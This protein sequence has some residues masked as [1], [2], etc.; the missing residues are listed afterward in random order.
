METKER[1]SLLLIIAALAIEAKMDL[2][3]QYAAETNGVIASRLSEFGAELS[4]S[5]IADKLKQAQKIKET[6]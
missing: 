3:H 5:N 6:Y 4:A 2:S 1:K